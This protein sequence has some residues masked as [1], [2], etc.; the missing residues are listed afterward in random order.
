MET[1]LIISGTGKNPAQGNATRAA[2]PYAELLRAASVKQI[3]VLESAAEARRMLLERDFDLVVVN[4]PLRDESGESF[5]R[6][7]VSKGASQAILVVK[8][9]SFGAVSAA[10]EADGVLTVSRPVDNAVFW[11]ALSLAKSARNRIRRVEEEN[12]RLKKKIEEIRIVDRAKHVLTARLNLSEPE[13]H[14]LIEKQAMDL[15]SSKRT[16]AEGILKSYGS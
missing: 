8:S 12:T 6:D 7:V 5:C 1:V 2:E 3:V 14:R 4:A 9:E 10:C 13:A 11:S 16:I 15:R